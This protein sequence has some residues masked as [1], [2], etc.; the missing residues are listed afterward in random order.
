MGSE[1]VTTPFEA[2]IHK[3]NNR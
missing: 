1:F 2:R 3:V